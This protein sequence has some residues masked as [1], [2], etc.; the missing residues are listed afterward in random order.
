MKIGFDLDG[1]LYPWHTIV[2]EHL[3]ETKFI[4]GVSF[5]DF[6]GKYYKEL[7]SEDEMMKVVNT[8]SLYIKRN[9]EAPILDMLNR[10]TKDH[11]LYYITSRPEHVWKS[12]K[13]WADRNNL[14]DTENLICMLGNGKDKYI[15][16]NKIDI[17]VDDRL[18]IIKI[19]SPHT[20]AILVR[21]P[22]NDHGY[23]EY[24]YVQNVLEVED[25]VRS[26]S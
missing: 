26:K 18:D 23:Q 24:N 17:Y 20:D 1:V 21:Q 11:T 10:L 6:W 4:D 12:T 22:Y 2:Y 16:D 13:R 7:L 14:P 25:Y 9:I 3:K 8:T 19:V 15:I 5:Q